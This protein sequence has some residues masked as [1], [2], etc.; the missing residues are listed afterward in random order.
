MK[1]DPI[2]RATTKVATTKKPIRWSLPSRGAKTDGAFGAAAGV[3]AESGPAPGGVAVENGG[4]AKA[5][6]AAR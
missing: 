5:V 3:A 6:N 2:A 1:P 4:F